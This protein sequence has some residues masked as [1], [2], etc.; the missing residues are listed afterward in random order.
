MSKIILYIFCTMFF[1]LSTVQC[2]GQKILD[3]YNLLSFYDDDI[4]L[5]PIQKTIEGKWVSVA[6]TG[7]QLTPSIEEKSNF[8]EII[9]NSSKDKFTLE[10]GLFERKNLPPVLAIVKNH[11]DIFLHGEV[12][13]LELKRDRFVDVTEK[14]LPKI[15]YQDFLDKNALGSFNQ[16]LNNHLEFGYELPHKGTKFKA[17]MQTAVLKEK[18]RTNTTQIEGLCEEVNAV[19]YSTIEFTWDKSTGT[20]RT[21]NKE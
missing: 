3:Y 7:M 12:H 2:F 19:K 14:V 17:K 13:F 20:F 1:T 10:V 18:C 15:T 11:Y 16:Q 4:A 5:Y 6:P 8:I 9:D 21:G